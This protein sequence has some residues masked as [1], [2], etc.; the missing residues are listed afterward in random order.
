[1]TKE[2]RLLESTKVEYKTQEIIK[3]LIVSDNIYFVVKENSYS[4]NRYGSR[5]NSSVT[6]I[7]T[8]DSEFNITIEGYEYS[9]EQKGDEVHLKDRDYY[10]IIKNEKIVFKTSDKVYKSSN[11]ILFANKEDNNKEIVH[12]LANY[13]RVEL[14]TGKL[15]G[16]CLRNM[17][18]A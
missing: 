16:S 18:V 9:I 11:G 17:G 2:L 13:K 10:Y 15:N 7:K 1:M 3:I 12:Y 4:I 6:Y 14:C 5:K 8:L